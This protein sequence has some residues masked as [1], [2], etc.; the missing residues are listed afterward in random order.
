MKFL[1]WL[2]LY[3][4]SLIYGTV[5]KIR[6]FMFNH[7]IILKSTK[8]D[9]PIIVVGNVS[10]GGTGKTPAVEYLTELLRNKYNIAVL[11]RGYKRK[12][13]GFV[14]ADNNAG[15]ETIG[16]EPYQIFL[17]YPDITVAVDENRV[18]GIHK[19]LELKKNINL[20]LLDDAFQHRYVKPALS[21]L[22]I[23]YTQPFFKDHYLP[24]GRLRDN[25]EE[26][27]RAELILIT[28][29][30]PS[31]KPIDMR[32]I[33]TEMKLKPYQ[34]LFFATIKYKGLMP[35]FDNS[36]FA[37]DTKTLKNSDYFIL[38]VTGIGNPKPIINYCKSITENIEEMSFPDHH[39]YSDK[40][41]EKIKNRFYSIKNRN[42]II[43][44]TEKD[45]LRFRY[46]KTHDKEFKKFFFWYPIEMKILNNDEQEFNK[47]VFHYIEKSN[48]Q[49]RFLSTKKN[50]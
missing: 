4:I 42:K 1:K 49:Y 47:L 15:V 35:V 27:Y 8:F 37:L 38:I 32:I 48:A 46:L 2:F 16:D 6:N 24:F 33:A 41:F 39:Q 50:Y 13:K 44:T 19:L 18:R 23:D 26:R 36:I 12:T 31:V 9:I 17:K 7:D 20:V 34:S 25:P 11:S 29:T 5:V 30:P 3:P 21:V 28:K 22:L 40:D 10:V 45:A 14:L 43:V